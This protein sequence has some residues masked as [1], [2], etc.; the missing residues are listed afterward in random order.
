M[1]KGT[2]SRDWDGLYVVWL[3]DEALTSSE[4][5]SCFLVINLIL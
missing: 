2:L 1:I 5:I 3:D 4:A